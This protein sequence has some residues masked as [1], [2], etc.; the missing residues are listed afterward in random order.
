MKPYLRSDRVSGLIQQVLADILQK[1][2]KDPRLEKATITGVKMSRDLRVARIY[3]TTSGGRKSSKQ[4]IEGFRSALGY[5][6]RTLAQQLGLRYMPDLKFF[7]DESLDY[8]SHI[9]KVLKS[10]EKDSV[11]KDNESNHT[12]S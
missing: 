6:K 8:G 3:F 1:S 5:V 7:Y 9:D 4:A 2:V 12:P 10:V 11:E